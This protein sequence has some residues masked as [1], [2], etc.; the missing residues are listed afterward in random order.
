VVALVFF[1]NR[2]PFPD[3]PD[4]R[5]IVGVSVCAAPVVRSSV[6]IPVRSSF[7]TA[8]SAVRKVRMPYSRV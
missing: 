5:T 2:L 8:A 4:M 1:E 6:A 7:F 3:L